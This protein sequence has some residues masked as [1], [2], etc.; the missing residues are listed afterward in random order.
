MDALE[1]I[2][3]A[4][5]DVIER[6][7]GFVH[8]G[9]RVC[10]EKAGRSAWMSVES[11][12]MK[13]YQ[14][15]CAL[16]HKGLPI[17]SYRR[18]IEGDDG[19]RLT[20]DRDMADAYRRRREER[21]VPVVEMPENFTPVHLGDGMYADMA[22]GYLRGRNL[23]PE[24]LW[25]KYMAAWVADGGEWHGRIVIPWLH[26]GRVAWVQGRDFTGMQNRWHN[27]GQSAKDGLLYNSKAIG[28]TRD[29]HLF[30][31]VFNVWEL[32]GEAVATGGSSL[33]DKQAALLSGH[34]GRVLVGYDEGAWLKSLEVA[35]KLSTYHPD[36][37]AVPL[38][39][40]DGGDASA[41]GREAWMRCVEGAVRIGSPGEAATLMHLAVLRE[42]KSYP[43]RGVERGITSLW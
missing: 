35:A 11:G 42:G 20:L 29:L 16:S 43:L 27:P 4:H 23:D 2:K 30:E 13:C 25:R 37:W 32:Q 41:M 3:T 34:R 10:G 9:C 5:P 21:Q 18:L 36:V 14:P 12:W 31:G 15:A 40:G 39:E 19:V 33:S 26:H 28:T 6:P 38:Y 1:W 17:D 7:G 8:F 22:R 24:E